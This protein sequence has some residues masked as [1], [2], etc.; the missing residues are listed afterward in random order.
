MLLALLLNFY[1]A[2]T[3]RFNDAATLILQEESFRLVVQRL[4]IDIV[5]LLALNQGDDIEI[6][7]QFALASFEKPCFLFGRFETLSTPLFHEFL[8]AAAE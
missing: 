5:H 7:G 6:L 4:S 2:I 3:I 1:H 8:A